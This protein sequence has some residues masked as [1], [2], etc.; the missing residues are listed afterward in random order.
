MHLICFSF[1]LLKAQL[2]SHLCFDAHFASQRY[3]GVRWNDGTT[4]HAR[5]RL[6]YIIYDHGYY[7]SQCPSVAAVHIVLICSH[8]KPYR[9]S[10]P[11]PCSHTDKPELSTVSLAQDHTRLSLWRCDQSR[12]EP[13]P[14]CAEPIVYLQCDFSRRP[15][16]GGENA[17][18][19][20]FIIQWTAF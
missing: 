5:N 3:L 16:R 14:R 19:C 8:P 6:T 11:S 12:Q 10:W 15:L 1:L 20:L 9:L 7:P 17:K 18:S 13:G 2:I 4:Y